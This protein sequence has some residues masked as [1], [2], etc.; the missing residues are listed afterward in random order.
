[1]HDAVAVIHRRPLNP[2]TTNSQSILLVHSTVQSIE[3][4]RWYKTNEALQEGGAYP[5][6]CNCTAYT[7]R[8]SRR[9]C[10]RVCPTKTPLK[11]PPRTPPPSPLFTTP[12]PAFLRPFGPRAKPSPRQ[13]APSRSYPPV[14]Q[15]PHLVV[16]HEAPPHR[17]PFVDIPVADTSHTDHSPRR[18]SP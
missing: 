13:R 1:M 6:H 17:R 14:G 16:A 5:C 12:P 8:S 2:E 4:K 11:T 7:P 9:D 15:L 3:L 18:T 10:L